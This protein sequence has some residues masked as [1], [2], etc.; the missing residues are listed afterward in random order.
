MERCYFS[1]ARY[2]IRVQYAEGKKDGKM[3]SKA[4]KGEIKDT[5]IY[6]SIVESHIIYIRN[7][8]SWM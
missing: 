2:S 8:F 4:N 5:E 6:L 7:C 3:L 1:G